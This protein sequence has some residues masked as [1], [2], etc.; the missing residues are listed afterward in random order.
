MLSCLKN[1]C[2]GGG[3]TFVFILHGE[4]IVVVETQSP[5]GSA[6]LS[7]LHII[8]SWLYL[9]PPQII[10]FSADNNKSWT[11]SLK[12]AVMN[13]LMEFLIGQNKYVQIILG[14][15]LNMTQM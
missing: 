5:V 6:L 2:E 13:F 14:S 1:K 10:K 9:K 12:K 4:V 3:F 8:A 15:V 7:L 11:L